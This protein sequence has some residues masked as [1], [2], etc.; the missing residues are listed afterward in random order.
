[1]I[2]PIRCGVDTLEA[3]FQGDLDL[4]VGKELFNR[5]QAAQIANSPEPIRLCGEDLFVGPQGLKLWQY[6][7]RNYDLMLKFSN[8]ENVPPMGIRMS[9]QGL[10]S[11]GVDALWRKSVE[12]AAETGL[13]PFNL[14]RID[15]AVDF[16]GW[17]PTFEEMQNVV[18]K[19]GFRPVYPNTVNPET[20]M[21]GKG[22]CV[23]RLYDKTKE[24][25]VKNHQWWHNVWK[26]H[27]YDPSLP[28]WRL[29]VQLRSG[30]L[31]ELGMRNTSTALE[32]IYGL[33][34]YGL[35]FASLREQASDSNLRRA[36]EHQAWIDLREQFSP[37]NLLGR[38]R[39]IATA[40]T[41]DASVARIAGL[42]A[43][44][45]AATGI[46]DYDEICRAVNGDVLRFIHN[47]REM[48]FAEL[49]E[50]KRRKSEYGK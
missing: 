29:E 46:T 43:N 30:A 10:A 5:K 8:A 35:D 2:T 11:R 15:V 1:M 14:T 50:D 6:V 21:F 31:K 39:P 32:N 41:Y 28:V 47:A 23:V 26:L 13:T 22:D 37:S 27:G 45:G 42:Y 17:I 38:I 4:W 20:F 18:C 24:I 34:C 44:A 40:M 3:T 25:A 33:F 12:I 19:S 48:D 16:Q 49:V 7:V 36:T 9:A